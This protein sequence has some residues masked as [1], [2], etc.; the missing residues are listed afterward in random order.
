MPAGCPAH[1]KR[2][3]NRALNIRERMKAELS[4]MV[5]IIQAAL[6]RLRDILGLGAE[7]RRRRDDPRARRGHRPAASRRRRETPPADRQARG[8]PISPASS[9]APGASA[10]SRC[11]IAALFIA[12]PVAPF[13]PEI[14]T[15]LAHTALLIAAIVLDRLDRDHRLAH[16]RGPLSAAVPARRRRQPARP[17]ARHPGARAAPRRRHAADHRDGRRRADDVRAG[18]PIRREPV[19]VRRRRRPDRRPRRA[20]GALA[21]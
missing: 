10:R 9:P 21:I 8:I 1:R 17:Q 11:V 18:A 4:G 14:A 3:R 20:A 12:L 19:R 5:E 6:A 7:H 16:P 15:S 13:N 2:K